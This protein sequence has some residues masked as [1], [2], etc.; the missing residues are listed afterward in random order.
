MDYRDERDALRGRVE[1]LEQDL[2]EARH[3]LEAE[4]G[5]DR[6]A[7]I[8]QLERQLGRAQGMLE[9]VR[10]ELQEAKGTSRTPPSSESAPHAG[11]AAQVP[12]SALVIGSLGLVGVLVVAIGLVGTTVTVLSTGEAPSPGLARFAETTAIGVTLGMVFVAC[13]R[14]EVRRSRLPELPRAV[15][16]NVLQWGSVVALVASAGSMLAAAVGSAPFPH[17]LSA[18]LAASWL[19]VLGLAIF[20]AFAPRVRGDGPARS[21]TDA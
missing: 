13:V 14:M 16:W 15:G 7:R 10:S 1:S 17:A 19:G 21:P 4:R 11:P 20:F 18:G 8:A 3:E 12:T 9:T 5:G 6:D 2:A